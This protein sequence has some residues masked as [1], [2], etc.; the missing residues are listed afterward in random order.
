MLELFVQLPKDIVDAFSN[1]D[2]MAGILCSAFVILL[3]IVA[4]LMIYGLVYLLFHRKTYSEEKTT[5][6]KV[7]KTSFVPEHGGTHVSP[8]VTGNG[9]VGMVATSDYEDEQDI[10]V[11]KTEDIG[12]ITIDNSELLE[13]VEK[14]D[15]VH[16]DYQEE[17]GYW[18]WNP[19][20]KSFN[21]YV[22]F[23][24]KT[25]DGTEVDL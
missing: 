10:V 3:L 24:A 7:V 17:Y 19:L 16:L 5:K 20:K 15:I 8:I 1:G 12:R 4:A 18:V 2:Y 13:N 11:I 25:K 23:K 21:D 6:G 22:P 9:T 14:G